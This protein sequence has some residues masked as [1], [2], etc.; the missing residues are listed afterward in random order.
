MNYISLRTVPVI[1]RNGYKKVVVNA[2]LDDGS[3][4]TYLNSDVADEL[5]LQSKTEKVTVNMINGKID[6]FETIPV[7]FQL[8]S[9]NGETKITVEAFTVNNVTG[10]LKAVNWANMSKS[11]KHLRKIEF[12]N[13]G[14]KPKID[15][16]IVAR[17]T[18]LG[19]TCVGGTGGSLQT[20]FT[21]ITSST[22]EIEDA[23]NTIKKLWEIEGDEEMQFRKIMTSPEDSTALNI[24]TYS[25]KTEN[26]RYELKLPWKGNRH[27]N[28][29]YT[30]ALNRLQNTEKRLMKNKSLG[31][32]YNNIIKQ[33]QEKGY[34][35]KINKR[36]LGDGWYLPHFLIL[37]PDK[38]TTKV[39]IVFDGSAKFNGKSINDVIYQG[40]KLQQD[41]VTVLL[42]FRKYPVALACDIAEMYLK[43]GIHKDDQ[44][45]QQ[46]LWRN[47]GLTAEPEVFQFNRLV[48]GINSPFMAQFVTQEHARKYA[49]KF[50]LASEAVLEATYMDDTI[51]SVVDEKVGIQL[52]KELKLLWGSAGMFARKWLSDSVEVKITP[53]NDRAEH[54][55]LD[56][57]ELP[58]MKTLRVVWKAKPDLFSFHSVTTEENTVYTKRILLK[59]MATLFDPLGFLAPYIIRIKI[60]MQKLCIDRIEWDETVPDR[61]A[62]NV[63]Q[64]FQELND[65]PKINIPR[66]LQTTSTVTNSI[67]RLELLGAVLG[68]RLAEKIVKALK[69]ETKDVTIWCGSLNVLWWIK[70]QSRKLKPF[71]ANR[72]EFIQSKTELKQWRYIPTKTNV[73]D[74]LTRGNYV[75]WHGPSFLNSL[76]EKWPQNHIEVTQEASIE[77]KKNLVLMNFALSTEVTKQLLDINKFSCWKK[78]VRINGWIHRFIG[79]C[80]FETDYRKKGDIAVDEYHESEKEII[81]KAQKESFKEEYSNIKKGK[82]ISISS[83]II[84]LNPQIDEDGLLRSCSRLQNAHYLPYDVK[85]PIILPRGHTITKLIVKHYH[86]EANHVMGTNQLLT[87]LLERY[88]VI[89]GREEIRDAEA[90]CN[91]CKLSRC[92]PAQQLMAPL[93]AMRF[94]EP[95]RA[96]ARI[97]I[98][99]AGP[100]LTMQGRGKIRQKRYLCLFTCLLSRAVHLEMAYN[101]DTNS[102]L[103]AFY[104]MVN[105]RGL[106]LEVLTD[107]GTNFVGG[108]RELNEIVNDLDKDKITNSTADKG[109]KWHFNASLGPH[110]GGVFEIMV[111]AVKRA[112]TGIL[113]KADITDEELCTAFTGAES[114]LNSRPLTYQSAN[115]KDDIPLTPNHFL[116]GQVGEQ[117]APD[118]VQS[119]GYHPKKRW[120]RV[121]EPLSHFWKR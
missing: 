106:P 58:A 10:N 87:K 4:K 68:L 109:I 96:F 103:N 70:N 3:T 89:R 5:S 19:W 54:I 31:E 14:P 64:W 81:A 112:M 52:Y 74:L 16:L 67:P 115:I 61:I 25:L 26:G 8:E 91:K 95:L 119:K 44:R 82:P 27:L 97:G 98:D 41:L 72:V 20:H 78:L 49:K 59:K 100:F 11:W 85:Y 114:L 101:L 102:F 75:W 66:C 111:K 76:E 28:N 47:L 38:S 42:R 116:I 32:E 57:G 6:S 35:E 2:L 92:R 45:Y 56:S 39:R 104:R 99:F 69:L 79:N 117:F 51:T 120:R 86:D 113:E 53:E 37:R 63:D 43:I 84:S 90:K 77:V 46:I 33:Y 107:N 7:E 24:V 80:R 22:K 30:M 118:S 34:L 1:L 40:P 50:P 15:I 88:W 83:K 12:P 18:P 9:L 55:N 121:Q 17:L 108:C 73:A 105:R 48:F 13:I 94:K 93:P 29:N 65:L 62:N 23:N 21:K 71:V 36:D 110:L 60:I